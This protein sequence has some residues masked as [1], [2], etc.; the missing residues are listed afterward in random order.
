MMAAKGGCETWL[1]A[2]QLPRA[3]D[4]ISDERQSA[5]PRKHV[6]QGDLRILH[7]P[8]QGKR[9]AAFFDSRCISDTSQLGEDDTAVQHDIQPRASYRKAT[10]PKQ[11]HTTQAVC[12]LTVNQDGWLMPECLGQLL[13]T[14]FPLG[15]SLCRAGTLTDFIDVSQLPAL[16]GIFPP[17]G[18]WRSWGAAS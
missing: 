7:K 9:D 12:F 2:Y 17:W 15:G 16:L 4:K 1:T 18:A 13:L 6:A 11:W 5:G 8:D 10:V 14:P 3:L